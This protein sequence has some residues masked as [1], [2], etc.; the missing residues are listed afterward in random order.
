M[1]GP[2]DQREVWTGGLMQSEILGK[3]RL[4]CAH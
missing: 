1:D 3:D 4:A 2:S